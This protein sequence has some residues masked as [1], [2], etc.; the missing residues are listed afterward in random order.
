MVSV[1]GP[2]NCAWQRRLAVVAADLA[3]SVQK[4]FAGRREP[5]GL[6]RAREQRHAEAGLQLLDALAQGWL[7]HVQPRRG[8]RKV[9][10]LGQRD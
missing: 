10:L 2:S 8:P 3:C 9:Q 4:R 7:G 6:A 5:H 1:R